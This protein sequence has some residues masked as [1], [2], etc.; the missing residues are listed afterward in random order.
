MRKPASNIKC[1]KTQGAL[2][3]RP[4]VSSSTN[5][6]VP[7]K[8]FSKNVLQ[9][10]DLL[11]NSLFSQRVGE[12][13]MRSHVVFARYSLPVPCRVFVP[14]TCHRF[15]VCAIPFLANVL[16]TFLFVLLT[17]KNLP[18]PPPPQK[19]RNPKTPKSPPWVPEVSLAQQ[20]ERHGSRRENRS[21]TLDTALFC[22]Q[23]PT[24]A[25]KAKSTIPNPS[26]NNGNA[27]MPHPDL[28]SPFTKRS[29]HYVA[30]TATA[31][32]TSL[33]IGFVRQKTKHD[34]QAHV[35]RCTVKETVRVHPEL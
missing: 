11:R 20:Q 5:P 34:A 35:K 30:L 15:I 33:V 10:S 6:K 17:P 7:K 19:N 18:N 9:K 2:S 32:G 13:E 24:R 12:R 8:P 28:S 21:F 1:F 3:T 4:R 26:K 29:S 14:Y 31:S 25:R 27:P 16:G 22:R 23:S